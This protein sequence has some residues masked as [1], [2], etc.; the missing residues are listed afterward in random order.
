MAAVG[1]GGMIS[2]ICVAAKV[3]M[4]NIKL[5]V[6]CRKNI[7]NHCVCVCVCVSVSVCVCVCSSTKF[8]TPYLQCKILGITNSR[9]VHFCQQC[10][11]D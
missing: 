5:C 8:L 4:T 11:A 9:S 3:M 7:C 1:G 10:I 2:G 6:H